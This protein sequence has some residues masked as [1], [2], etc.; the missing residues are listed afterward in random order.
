MNTRKEFTYGH[1]P[2]C[3]QH[4][5]LNQV[6]QF[7]FMHILKYSE[8]NVLPPPLHWAVQPCMFLFVCLF[9][10]T[11]ILN[12]NR[13]VISYMFVQFRLIKKR[14]LISCMFWIF[15]QNAGSQ[16]CFRYFLHGERKRKFSICRAPPP[17]PPPPPSG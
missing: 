4:T 11:G 13:Q 2:V 12:T 5:C 15:F 8:S 17:P 16:L 14:F 7:C 6:N 1:N 9:V 3:A 10:V